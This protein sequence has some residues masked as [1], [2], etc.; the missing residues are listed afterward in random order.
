MDILI[1]AT[2]YQ[3]DNQRLFELIS[4]LLSA[5]DGCET[6]SIKSLQSEFQR[7]FLV[8]EGLLKREDPAPSFERFSREFEEYCS[9]LVISPRYI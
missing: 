1:K 2:V 8:I 5:L 7:A 3:Q 4:K 6:G 9:Q